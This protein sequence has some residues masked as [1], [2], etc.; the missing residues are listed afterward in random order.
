[1]DSEPDVHIQTHLSEN[2]TEIQE[3]LRSF[4][5]CKSYTEVYEKYG[6]LRNGTILAHCVWLTEQEMDV[7]KRTGAG[8]SHCPTS[9]FNLMSGGARVGAMLD[10]GLNVSQ[11]CFQSKVHGIHISAPCTGWIGQRLLRRLCAWS[12]P[13][14]TK[15]VHAVQDVGHSARK[16]PWASEW[17]GWPIHR[18]AIIDP[19]TVLPRHD[20]WRSSLQDGR[21]RFLPGKEFDALHVTPGTSPNF[22]LDVGEAKP[23]GQTR[24]E[25]RRKLKE[26]FERFLFVSDD[27]DIAHV[28]VRGRK[29]GGAK[30]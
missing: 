21:H 10:K 18:Q 11:T 15:C 27:R 19:D 26:T 13:A 8:I 3:T 5:E 16:A 24:D 20:G 2:R 29:V 6:M 28:Y 25:R 17:S 12:P 9:N 30:Q 14:I 1:M 22:F 7:I 4:P 23:I